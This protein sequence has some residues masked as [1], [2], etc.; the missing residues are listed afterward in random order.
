[1]KPMRPL[2]YADARWF[3]LL[4]AAVQAPSSITAVAAKLGY[5]R[6]AISQVINGI[7]AGKPDKIA[8]KVMELMDRW[9]C[10]Y[11]N[12]EIVAEDCRSVHTG[13][14][15]SHDPARLAQRRVC[16]TCKHNSKGES[17]A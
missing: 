9:E 3:K 14:T 2:P 10:P 8:A 5:G 6:P 17:H 13:P 4:Q 15:P 12:T 16:R 11:L 7:Y 1:M